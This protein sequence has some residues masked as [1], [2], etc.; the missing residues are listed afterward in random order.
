MVNQAMHTASMWASCGL[1]VDWPYSSVSCSSGRVFSDKAMVD[2]TMKR[3]EMMA[4]ICE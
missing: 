4:R 3:M 1:S 2:S